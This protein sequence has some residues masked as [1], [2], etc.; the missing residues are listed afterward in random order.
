MTTEANERHGTDHEIRFIRGI[1]SHANIKMCR[2]ELLRKYNESCKHRVDW[3]GIDK[4][5]VIEFAKKLLEQ[6]G[7]IK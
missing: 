7:N 5:R 6:E 3:Y 1:G 2:S 4:D